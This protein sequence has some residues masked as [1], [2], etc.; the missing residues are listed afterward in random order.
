M[1][2]AAQAPAGVAS[3]RLRG[4]AALV[5]GGTS[6]IGRAIA[7]R[8][9]AEGADVVVASRSR[10]SNEGPVPTDELIREA[11][12]TA[13]FAPLDVNDPAAVEQVVS[14]TIESR[15]NLHILVYSAG[16][17]TGGDSRELPLE[18][19]DRQFAVD[20]RGAFLCARAAL[21]HFV[22]KRHGKIVLVSSN[23]GLVGV[24]GLA[25]Y[26]S[27]KAAVIGLVRALAVEYGP[28][29]VNVNALLPGATHT[30]SSDPFREDPGIDEVWRRMTP[31]RMPGD[32]FVAD[33]ED[34][35][36]AA[37]FLASDESRAMT[38]Q[39]LVVD[40]GWTAL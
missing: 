8:F 14:R 15:G 25:A 19:F 1:S 9:A 2:D 21:K 5:V 37:V 32:A 16:T 4:S 38:G 10:E 18:D 39:G 11:G 31:L 3:A 17:F 28:S 13:E 20:V 12:G 33:A 22:P 30:A 35:A 40:G 26:C 6:G 7:L 27:A 29:G 36:S 24:A 23:F 34:V